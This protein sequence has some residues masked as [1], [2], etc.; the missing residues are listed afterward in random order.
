MNLIFNIISI[1]QSIFWVEETLANLCNSPMFPPTKP[2]LHMVYI[3]YTVLFTSTVVN[4][5]SVY[6]IAMARSIILAFN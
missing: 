3:I 6:Y 5:A 4:I 1:E 2:S